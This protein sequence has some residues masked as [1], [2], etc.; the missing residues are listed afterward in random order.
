MTLLETPQHWIDLGYRVDLVLSERP[1]RIRGDSTLVYSAWTRLGFLD[2][3]IRR[4]VL[5]TLVV[6]VGGVICAGALVVFHQ[7]DSLSIRIDGD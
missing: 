5:D 7:G 3:R 4:V 1:Q 2:I 6:P